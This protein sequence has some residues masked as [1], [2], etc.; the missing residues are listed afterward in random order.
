MIGS[1]KPG[2]RHLDGH[3]TGSGGKP[4]PPPNLH[5]K[6]KAAGAACMHLTCLYLTR[7]AGK[8]LS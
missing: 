4:S 7:P 2:P 6:G 1:G 5:I 3:Q 8:V